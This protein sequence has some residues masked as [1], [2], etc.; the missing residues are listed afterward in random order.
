M[1]GM[2]TFY[3]RTFLSFLNLRP[4]AIVHKMFK[5]LLNRDSE[6]LSWELLKEVWSSEITSQ[7]DLLILQS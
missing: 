7:T 3:L 4:A 1:G 6:I 2:N 5:S